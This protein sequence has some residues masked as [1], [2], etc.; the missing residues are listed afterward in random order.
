[1]IIKVKLFLGGKLGN[2]KEYYMEGF[3]AAQQASSL[4]KVVDKGVHLSIIH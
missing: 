2:S 3:W 4:T 1:M